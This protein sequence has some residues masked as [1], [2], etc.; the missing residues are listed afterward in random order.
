MIDIVRTTAE[1]LV[2]LLTEWSFSRD[3]DPATGYPE[4]VVQA[5]DP[6]TPS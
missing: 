3:L 2:L 5:I 4:L 6:D 1:V